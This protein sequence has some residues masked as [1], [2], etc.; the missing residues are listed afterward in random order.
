MKFSLQNGFWVGAVT[1]AAWTFLSLP[2][3]PAADP[4]PK[5]TTTN[6]TAKVAKSGSITEE[7]LGNLLKAMCLEAKK[8]K[9]RYD[10]EFKAVQNKEEW[11]P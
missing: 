9:S 8:I 5:P 7:Q 1:V 6:A 4:A 11:N 2:S 3:L 10:F